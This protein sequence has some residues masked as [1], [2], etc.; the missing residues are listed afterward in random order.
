MKTA[1]MDCAHRKELNIELR[2]GHRHNF[3]TGLGGGVRGGVVITAHAKIF[4]PIVSRT[5]KYALKLAI[6]F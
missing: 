1:M 3:Q 5:L 4:Y 6:C 2:N